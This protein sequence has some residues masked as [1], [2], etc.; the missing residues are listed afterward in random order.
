MNTQRWFYFTLRNRTLKVLSGSYPFNGSY[1]QQIVFIT[2]QRNIFSGLN[3]VQIF[4]LA[5]IR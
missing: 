1:E 5:L 4:T 3:F 2:I